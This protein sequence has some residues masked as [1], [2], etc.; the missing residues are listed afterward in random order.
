MPRLM[1]LDAVLEAREVTW[2]ASEHDKVEHFTTGSGIPR[3]SLP[4]QASRVR[5]LTSFRLFPD[6][7]PIGVERRTGRCSSTRPH[8]HPWSTSD[9]FFGATTPSWL[10]FPRG[11]SGSS[12]RRTGGPRRLPGRRSSTTK[13]DRCSAS[14]APPNAA[15]NGRRSATATVISLPWLPRSHGRESGLSR[16][17]RRGNKPRALNPPGDGTATTAGEHQRAARRAG[18]RTNNYWPCVM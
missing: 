12:S 17:N 14:L 7:L 9:R 5:G 4:Q 13:S 11:R 8:A 3:E 2:L 10:R 1:L 16:G 15:S 18:F 6:A